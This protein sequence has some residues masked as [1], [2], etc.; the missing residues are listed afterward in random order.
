MYK[1]ETYRLLQYEGL[2]LFV[3]SRNPLSEDDEVR[4]I[5]KRSEPITF[6][7]SYLEHANKTILLGSTDHDLMR[8]LFVS[9]ERIPEMKTLLWTFAEVRS[10]LI[11]KWD[12]DFGIR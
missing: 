5:Q 1:D 12:Q 4:K 6:Y 9:K 7:P 2:L 3:Y 11:E 8:V 10:R